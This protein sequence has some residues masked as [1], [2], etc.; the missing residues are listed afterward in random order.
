MIRYLA[1]GVLLLGLSGITVTSW[2]LPP[3]A[4]AEVQMAQNT[5]REA[6]RAAEEA[7]I[8]AEKARDDEKQETRNVHEQAQREIRLGQERTERDARWTEAEQRRA[9]RKAHLKALIER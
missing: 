9:Q 6:R 4:A 1:T 8:D 3:V 5:E 7:E 2:R